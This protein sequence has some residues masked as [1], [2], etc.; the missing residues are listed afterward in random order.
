MRLFRD[1]ARG[2]GAGA[3]KPPPACR[4]PAPATP[5]PLATLHKQDVVEERRAA[6][7][8]GGEGKPR[9]VNAARQAGGRQSK[10]RCLSA[11]ESVQQ[12]PIPSCYSR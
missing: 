8:G 6:S 9:D 10:R 12:D 11:I 4:T 1:Q 7:C 5:R 2:I 3:W